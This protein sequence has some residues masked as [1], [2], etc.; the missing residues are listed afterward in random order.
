MASQIIASDF[1]G[2]RFGRL[3][4]TAVRREIPRVLWAITACDCGNPKDVR[5]HSLLRGHTRS[6][7]CLRREITSARMSTHGN[8]RPLNRTS[9]Y[10]IWTNM[11]QR[12][13]NPDNPAF[14]NYGGRGI[15]V[16]E[17]WIHSFDNFLADMGKRPSDVHEIERRDNENGYCPDNCYWAT[18]QQQARNKR[19]SR[20][21]EHAGQR[22]ILDDWAKQVGISRKT[23]TTRLRD[24]WSVARTLTEPAGMS[25]GSNHHKRKTRAA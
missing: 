22:M 12:C 16:S 20:Y 6:C 4:V 8:S 1:I 18:P 13:T 11:K 14:R 5:L 23:L 15:T 10:V 24:G 7:G 2:K 19:T 9:E 17:R 3:V 25:L 21:F